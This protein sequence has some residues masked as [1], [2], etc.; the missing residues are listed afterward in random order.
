MGNVYSQASEVLLDLG[1]DKYDH[2]TVKGL[3]Q[4]TRCDDDLWEAAA[5]VSRLRFYRVD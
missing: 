2:E 3:K 5:V 1:T 4:Y